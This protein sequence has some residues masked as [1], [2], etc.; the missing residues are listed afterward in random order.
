[1]AAFLLVPIAPRQK[2]SATQKISESHSKPACP[3]FIYFNWKA[4]M[5]VSQNGYPKMDGL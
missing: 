5:G 2:R 4:K 1:M 3:S